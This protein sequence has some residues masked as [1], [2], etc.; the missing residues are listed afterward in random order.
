MSDQNDNLIN[1]FVMI[2]LGNVYN[3]FR[4]TWGG[5]HRHHILQNE[6]NKT[7]DYI[8]LETNL[9]MDA[10]RNYFSGTSFEQIFC[11][12]CV[13]DGLMSWKNQRKMNIDYGFMHS[14]QY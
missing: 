7:N 14:S 5:T 8:I 3:G 12:S 13:F 4:M 2:K 6:N 1:L 10:W 11:T 9:N